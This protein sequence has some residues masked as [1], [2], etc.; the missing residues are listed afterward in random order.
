[1]KTSR[2]PVNPVI[3]PASSRAD[4]TLVISTTGAHFCNLTSD[5]FLRTHSMRRAKGQS[6]YFCRSRDFGY[7]ASGDGCC[8]DAGDFYWRYSA[9]KRTTLFAA[10]ACALLTLSL[11]GCG[12]TNHLQTI[13]LGASLV[14]GAAP[15]SQA[16][17]FSLQGNGGT[18]QLKA[19]GNYSSSK[20][21]DLSN[22]VTYTLIV[23]PINNV[24]AYGNTLLP[25]CLGPC[26]SAAQGTVE[27]NASGLVT[28]V[29]PATCTWV[30]I[31]PDPAKPAWFYSGAYRV[32][33]S[34]QGIQSQPMYIPIAS[35][36]GNPVYNGVTNNPTGLCGPTK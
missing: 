31:S 26:K 22:E 25:P 34:F 1:M 16:G 10:F 21:K 30:D 36:A 2:S 8:D 6:G 23:D 5:F 28:A 12:A 11:L 4:G 7:L 20:T 17:F 24:D 13:T 19:T 3:A 33:A 14:N 27:F 32:T 18:I 29:D 9:V 35:S 15:G